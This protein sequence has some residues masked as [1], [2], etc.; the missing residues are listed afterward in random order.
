MQSLTVK[1]DGS[2]RSAESALEATEAVGKL[3]GLDGKARLRLR[4]LAEEMIGTLVGVAGKVK[5]DYRIEAEEKDFELHLKAELELTDEMRELLI[6]ASSRKTNDAAR[7]FIGKIRVLIADILCSA[8]DVPPY[9]MVNTV[10][11][12][13][14]GDL[15]VG[16]ASALWSMNTYKEE[17][18]RDAGKSKEAREA[19]DELEKSIIANVAD[20]VKVRIAGEKV[21]M[22]VYKKF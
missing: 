8:K 19:W 13:T 9:A 16:C 20:D 11:E 18:K 6:S 17:I 2:R 4:L 5:A 14:A 21:E 12:Y 22:I 7:G 1:I 10:S 3:Q 15:A